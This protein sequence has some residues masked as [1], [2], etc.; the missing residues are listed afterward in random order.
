[1]TTKI[2]TGT[3]TAGYALGYPITTLSIAASGYVEGQGIYTTADAKHHYRVV[4][5][6]R[7]VAAAYLEAD[8][9]DLARGGIVINGQPTDHVALISG[10]D[11]VYLGAGQN[12]VRNFGA[13]TGEYY[14]GVVLS[15]G[16]EVVN[17]G[18]R[19]IT[20]RIAG[21]QNGVIISGGVGTVT[22]FGT[23]VDTSIVQESSANAGL[24]DR[25]GG[26]VVNGSRKDSS[27]VIYGYQGVLLGG[28]DSTVSNFG[29][30]SADTGYGVE[31]FGG[32][33]VT[34]G[35]KTDQ[36]ALI[37]GEVGSRYGATT[38]TN[39][40][41][42]EA[43]GRYAGVSLQTGQVVNGSAHAP[44]ALIEG[45]EGVDVGNGVTVTNFGTLWGRIGPAVDFYRGGGG[46]SR[47]IEEAGAVIVGYANGGGGTLELAG[48]KGVITA[49]YG[50]L[51]P[52]G[53]G[54]TVTSD[55]RPARFRYFATLDL[56]AGGRFS[57]DQVLSVGAGF[58]VDT[59]GE[60]RL[61][62]TSQSI[63]NAGVIET[64]G[65]GV[66]EIR[67]ALVNS[68]TL[69]VAGGAVTVTGA[70]TGAGEAVIIRGT[71]DLASSASQNVTFGGHSGVLILGASRSYTGT[72]GGFSQAGAD[73][74]D[75]GDIA[76]VDAGEATFSGTGSGGMLTVSDGTHTAQIKLAGN[77]LDATFVASDDGSGGV[78]VIAM[79]PDVPATVHRFVAAAAGISRASAVTALQ[80]HAWS[81]PGWTLTS[82]THPELRLA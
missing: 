81:A 24:I 64:T 37:R 31:I 67:G 26:L 52:Q 50:Q 4:N 3:Y 19:D 48:G 47:L 38:V 23:I 60:L 8:G 10:F 39:Y 18:A 51:A 72:L 43:S 32:G 78:N 58:T 45:F 7:V 17:G 40:G 74:L 25:Y 70:A 28:H 27:A 65:G 77:Y 73:T 21:Y 30:I 44:H 82:P 46:A 49:Y 29:T 15:K 53:D 80:D 71:L 66:C 63:T 20:A 9:V 54:F 11:G 57:A 16:G 69:S 2:L 22:N 6:G 33:V 55:A 42:I 61:G 14:D 79:S 13:I 34:N 75:L 36:R 35:S 62:V 12:R 5:D 41:R 56:D 76:F 1:M 68:G 59:M